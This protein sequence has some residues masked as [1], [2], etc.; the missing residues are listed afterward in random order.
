MKSSFTTALVITAALS[1]FSTFAQASYSNDAEYS[2]SPS[3]ISSV[4]RDAVCAE[5]NS[6]L[7]NGT[8]GVV[9]E[10]N[11]SPLPE[12]TKDS[13]QAGKTRAEVVG[14]LAMAH[15]NKSNTDRAQ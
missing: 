13:S 10:R 6:A 2:A 15:L 5:L 4:S 14:E 9:N 3:A 12:F 7:H 11:Y 8:V 1:A